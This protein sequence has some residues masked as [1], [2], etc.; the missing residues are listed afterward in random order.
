ML[1]LKLYLQ[2]QIWSKIFEITKKDLQIQTFDQNVL[3]TK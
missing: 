2:L 3:V 1:A